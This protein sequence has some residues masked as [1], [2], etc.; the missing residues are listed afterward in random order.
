MGWGGDM[1]SWLRKYLDKAK[2]LEMDMVQYND[3]HPS[4]GS[5]ASRD[6][7]KALVSFCRELEGEYLKCKS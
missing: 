2:S 7:E 6:L 5:E 1:E 4:G 3:A